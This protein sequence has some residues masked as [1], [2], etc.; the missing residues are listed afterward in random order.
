MMG[1][2][3]AATLTWT[4]AA[5]VEGLA[6]GPSGDVYALMFGGSAVARY[7]PDGALK[8][9]TFVD[10]TA[11][12]IALGALDTLVV[13]TVDG[14]GTSRIE[15]WVGKS[16]VDAFDAPTGPRI[17]VG[18]D[19]LIYL[20]SK[21]DGWRVNGQGSGEPFGGARDCIGLA[22]GS[23]GAYYLKGSN[24]AGVVAYDGAGAVRWSY[25]FPDDGS[26]DH[27]PLRPAQA[28]AAGMAGGLYLAFPDGFERWTSDGTLA[29]TFDGPA[30]RFIASNGGRTF[31]AADGTTVYRYDSQATTP[32]QHASLGVVKARWR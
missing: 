9:V 13:F 15:R 6:V 28:I 16:F 30:A 24:T 10:G 1:L 20:A 29:E 5:P 25:Y 17:G 4:T 18:P 8:T 22:V 3:L 23:A 14:N 27:A 12:G 7:N 32:V 19:G 26:P 31:Y 21:R 2:M 11:Q